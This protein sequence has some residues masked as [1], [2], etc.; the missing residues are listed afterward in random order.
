[1]GAGVFFLT[2]A[3][4]LRT[5]LVVEMADEFRLSAFAVG[6]LSSAFALGR[7]LTDLPAGRAADRVPLGLMMAVASAVV[8][9]GSA[10]IAV[11]PVLAILYAG[12][13]V[14]GIGSASILT[15]SFAFFAT[16]PRARRGRYL[17][18]FAAAML[19]GQAMGPAAGGLLSIA[20]GWRLAMLAAVALAALI[21]L[22]FVRT[23]TLRTDPSHAVAGGDGDPRATRLVLAI[24]YLMPA[25]QFGVGASLYQ[26]L[27]PLVG[28]NQLGFST[29]L[30]GIGL[31][32][33]GL[34]RFV[35]ALVSGRIS[36]NVSRKAALVP[37]IVL[38]FGGVFAFAAV[39]TAAGWWISVALLTLGS[40]VVNVGSTIL[41]D[42]S[43]GTRLGRRLGAFRFTGDAAFLVAPL[44]TGALFEAYGRMAAALPLLI[45]IGAAF[46]GVIVLVP[47]TN[48]RQDALGR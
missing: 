15:A 28:A 8:A 18:A 4:F 9:I 44:I 37:G 19:V 32:A 2:V 36:D 30:V 7:L 22:G 12:V 27:L 16:A 11:S 26:T 31:G 33:G 21:A 23:R 41:A 25:V 47:E 43:E 39:E 6:A 34:S 3:I 46:V 5:P 48:P 42:L 17:S 20:M 24:L 1:M 10:L 13:F 29:A 40:V 45:L 14:L 35:A 38:Q